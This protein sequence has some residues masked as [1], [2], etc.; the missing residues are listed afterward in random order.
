MILTDGLINDMDKAMDILVECAT[1]PLSVIIIG[2][3]NTDFTLMHN[4][5]NL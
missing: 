2:I 3:G 5:G 4:L 1:Y